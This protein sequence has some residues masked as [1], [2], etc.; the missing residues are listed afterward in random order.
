[1]QILQIQQILPQKEWEENNRAIWSARVDPL[2]RSYSIT[3]SL[4]CY[5]Y[6]QIKIAGFP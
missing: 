5:F 4:S 1:M 2:Y 3:E 6:Y